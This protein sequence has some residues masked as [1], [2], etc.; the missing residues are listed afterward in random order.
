MLEAS[1]GGELAGRIEPLEAA[2]GAADAVPV[3]LT[4]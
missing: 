4:T 2:I 1:S 3:F